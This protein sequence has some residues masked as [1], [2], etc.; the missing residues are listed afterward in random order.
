MGFPSAA[1]LNKPEIVNF[2][3]CSAIALLCLFCWHIENY[4]ALEETPFSSK[5]KHSHSLL[6]AKADMYIQKIN[7]SYLKCRYIQRG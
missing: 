5:I 6:S 4:T 3:R 1:F 2:L 7:K